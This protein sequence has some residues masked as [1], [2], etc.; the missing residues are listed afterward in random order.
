M[1]RSTPDLP[2]SPLMVRRSDRASRSPE[3]RR[4][5]S[6]LN[7]GRQFNDIESEAGATKK[8][9]RSISDTRPP[10]IRKTSSSDAPPGQLV[11]STSEHHLNRTSSLSD[12]MRRQASLGGSMTQLP[13]EVMLEIILR[14]NAENAVADWRELAKQYEMTEVEIDELASTGSE[15]PASALLHRMVR[16]GLTVKLLVT[17]LKNISRED[18]VEV[19]RKANIWSSE[20]D[21][22]Q[23]G[24]RN[25]ISPNTSGSNLLKG[26]SRGNLDSAASDGHRPVFPSPPLSPS[27]ALQR[28]SLTASTRRAMTLPSSSPSPLSR[29]WSMFNGFPKVDQSPRIPHTMSSERL[30]RVSQLDFQSMMES[31]PT[32]EEPSDIKKV[33]LVIGN[34]NYRL[35]ELKL[36]TPENDASAI[37]TRLKS[38]GWNVKCRLNVPLSVMKKDLQSLCDSCCR[39]RNRAVFVFYAGHAVQIDG[40]NYA[41]PIS[42]QNV[43]S[44]SYVKQY[45]LNLNSLL[46]GLQYCLM[47]V[48]VVS[49]GYFIPSWRGASGLAVPS[50]PPNCCFAMSYPPS[51]VHRN[52]EGSIPGCCPY[53]SRFV[54]QLERDQDQPLEELLNAAESDAFGPCHFCHSLSLLRKFAFQS[55]YKKRLKNA[56]MCYA[57]I[58]GNKNLRSPYADEATEA[59][60]LANYLEH[61]G[62]SVT[63]EENVVSARLVDVIYDFLY[64]PNIQADENCTVM[65]FFV[66]QAIQTDDK[67][68]FIKGSDSGGSLVFPE[69][70]ENAVVLEDVMLM[71][72]EVVAGPKLLTVG[73]S[74]NVDVECLEQTSFEVCPW[75]N[76]LVSIFATESGVMRFVPG[77]IQH[78]K[79]YPD[80]SLLEIIQTT[81]PH[82]N[83]SCLFQV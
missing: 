11:K 10:N 30:S 22:Q 81:L 49:S 23:E 6:P 45:G 67:V 54:Q 7:T 44:S 46:K 76:M 29:S 39:D 19:L 55:T 41:L 17:Y 16:A 68:V 35:E 9:R 36:Q 13:H 33:A 25:H 63:K 51:Q 37:E 1:A 65:V 48:V 73:G 59:T 82:S 61:I 66:G 42:I 28:R 74:W 43:K 77:L 50:V 71:M 20:E 83:W 26:L 70:C 52:E 57:L 60:D 18:I 72:A 34:S 56:D 47:S 53:V 31:L 3:F 5:W 8:S 24:K 69:L 80:A 14:L 12:V 75:H 32:L 21:L 27:A 38:Y 15:Q 64:Q 58:I 4:S 62:W 78:W 2:S 40:E 79:R